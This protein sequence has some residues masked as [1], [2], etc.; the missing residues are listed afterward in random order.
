ME[1]KYQTKRISTDSIYT[2]GVASKKIGIS[3]YT[4][5]QYEHEGLIIINRSEK[6]QRLLSDVELLK[7]K[8]IKRMIKEE[9]LNFNGIRRLFTLIPCWKLRGCTDKVKNVCKPLKNKIVP[10]WAS[11]VKCSDPLPSCRDCPVYKNIIGY[12]DLIDL[13]YI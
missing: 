7:V 2:M 12:D 6:G 8:N 3:S 1:T 11:D 5:R 9:G 10:C 4:I 13:L